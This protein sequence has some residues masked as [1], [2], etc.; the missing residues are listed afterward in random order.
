[1]N[2]INKI[3][4]DMD[5]VLADFDEGLKR[6]CGVEPMPQGNQP[7]EYQDKMWAAMRDYGNFYYDLYPMEGAVE[8][9]TKLFEKYG[10]KL[11]VL[12]AIPKPHR[13]MDSAKDDKLKWM[14]KY[15]PG[16]IVVNIVFRAEKVKY[17]TGKDSIL[18]DDWNVNTDEWAKNGGTAIEFKSWEQIREI[19]L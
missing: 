18:I 15:F 8:V 19:L 16:E 7:Q 2:N 3:Y 6:L 1:M 5:G 13:G 14:K 9:F 12:T 10:D 4:V 11:E 17:C